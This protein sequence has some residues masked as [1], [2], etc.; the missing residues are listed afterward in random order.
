MEKKESEEEC[1]LHLIPNEEDEAHHTPE[2]TCGC[3][4]RLMKAID[5]D[6]EGDVVVEAKIWMHNRCH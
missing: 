5:E 4:P 2:E 1:P 3:E 6:D